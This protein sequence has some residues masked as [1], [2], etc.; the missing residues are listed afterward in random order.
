MYI[1]I[2]GG[3]FYVYVQIGFNKF[4]PGPYIA[5]YHKYIGTFIMIICYISFLL[6]SWSKPGVIKK[7]NL[8]KALQ[9]FKYDGVLFKKGE[10]CKTCKMQKPARSKHCRLCG[11]CVEKFD[12]HCIWVNNCVG[13]YNYRWFLLFLLT[14]AIICIYG[15]FAGIL[16]F[17]GIIK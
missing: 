17:A 16:I 10:E 4:I 15:T 1:I 3:G 14:H 12:H 9:R 13:Y 7:T 2:A 6:A 11:V 5:S 8:Q